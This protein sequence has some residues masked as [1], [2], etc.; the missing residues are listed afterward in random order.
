MTRQVAVI[1]AAAEGQRPSAAALEA[2]RSEVGD[3][4]EVVVVASRRFDVPEINRNGQF[5]VLERPESRLIPELWR[6]GL[7]EVDAK[8][9]AFSTIQM[10]PKAG[11]LDALN[12]R[13]EQTDAWGVGGPIAA[14]EH[15]DAIDRAIYLLR[16]LDYAPD[17]PR[18]A[19][20][21]PGENALYRLDRLNDVADA[22]ADGFWEV[23]V[24][25]RLESLGGGWAMAPDA[26]LTFS[27]ATR[28]RSILSQR[29]AHARRYGADRA[30]RWGR[31]ER[32]MRIA[33]APA[34]PAVLFGRAV[35]TLAE[36][37]ASL[38][39]WL[40]AAPWF[41][42]LAGAWASGEMLGAWLGAG[43]ARAGISA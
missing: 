16:H 9:V 21:P 3:R 17:S 34:V 39:P 13:L 23:D 18:P 14:G 35:R 24:Q 25:R 29:L 8:H 28:L 12:V 22:W 5:R 2:F 31:A 1:L 43:P 42:L 6:D 40:A 33:A 36:R 32:L 19:W 26:V 10:T 4:G 41:F 11:W 27:G 15:L 38:G 7:R 30:S 20:R 37:R